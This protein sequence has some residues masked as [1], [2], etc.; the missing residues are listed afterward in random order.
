MVMLRKTIG[1]TGTT[2]S[3]G[4]TGTTGI[5]GTIGSIGSIG[6][7]DGARAESPNSTLKETRPTANARIAVDAMRERFFDFD[8][9]FQLPP[10]L[11]LTS[12]MVKI[13][14]NFLQ[15]L[16][17]NLGIRGDYNGPSM[18][19]SEITTFGERKGR[20]EPFFAGF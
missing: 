14:S 8:F 1:T 19:S 17:L 3:I 13:V 9:I 11:L 18:I 6:I 5:T 20:K 2:G 16:R 7:I 4:S 15:K 12:M 10:F